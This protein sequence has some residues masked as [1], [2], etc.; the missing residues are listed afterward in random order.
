MELSTQM[1]L[2]EHVLEQNKRV[3]KRYVKLLSPI[4]ELQT[5]DKIAWFKTSDNSSK[6]EVVL[7]SFIQI[8][9]PT[10]FNS[11]YRWYYCQGRDQTINHLSLIK[12]NY[13]KL[14]ND[15]Y[16][17]CY[18]KHIYKQY[19]QLAREIIDFNQ[20]LLNG[21]MT[22]KATYNDDNMNEVINNLESSIT[23]FKMNIIDLQTRNV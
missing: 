18:M 13:V 4:L 12:Q 1:S 7:A 2:Q 20:N 15:I 3:F 16:Y 14:L 10:Y 9:K 8:N 23:D 11:F 5:G 17:G 19:L 21:F 6:L 22:L